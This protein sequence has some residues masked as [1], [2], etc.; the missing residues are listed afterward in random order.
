MKGG[1][2]YMISEKEAYQIA[3]TKAGNSDCFIRNMFISE[4]GEAYWF[5]AIFN[6]Y[7]DL[8]YADDPS[9]IGKA[10]KIDISNGTVTELSLFDMMDADL[11]D[12]PIDISGFRDVL[13]AS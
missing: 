9:S 4:D 1:Y 10:Y 12:E 8:T 5:S 6:K 7:A 3:T 13:R 11:I 2:I